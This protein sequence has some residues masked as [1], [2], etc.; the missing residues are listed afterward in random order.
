MALPAATS[1]HL[2][3]PLSR[4]PL[5]IFLCLAA[6]VFV[7]ARPAP[8]FPLRLTPLAIWCLVSMVQFVVCRVPRTPVLLPSLPLIPCSSDGRVLDDLC[9]LGDYSVQAESTL[10][11][12]VPLAGGKV[13]RSPH[14]AAAA[15]ILILHYTTGSR[16]SCACRKGAWPDPQGRQANGQAQAREGPCQASSAIQPAV[17]EHRG[18]RRRQE[19]GAPCCTCVCVCVGVCSVP[20]PRLAWSS[21]ALWQGPNTQAIK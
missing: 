14:F 8:Y 3:H 18:W 15:T 13:G 10:T 16:F 4:C 21:H 1:C 5:C 2:D 11:L 20:A 17:Q 19:E 12:A 6:F 7:C 9:T